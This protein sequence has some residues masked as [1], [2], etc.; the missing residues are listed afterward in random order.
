M[1]QLDLFS[2]LTARLPDEEELARRFSYFNQ[3]YFEGS[4]P[5][6]NVLW[7]SRMRIAGTCDSRRRV[8]TLSRAYH[9]HFPND[10]DD[11]LKH[12]MI[13]LKQHS[14]DAAFRREA[15]RVGA[16]IHCKEYP[17]L[18]PRARFV[19]ICPRC[20]TLFHRS[21][22]ER[23]YCGLCARNRLDARFILVL[24]PSARRNESAV[25]LAARRP[26]RNRP[27]HRASH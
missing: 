9:A 20:R 19:Y 23:L 4:L 14:H 12:E 5:I 10:V 27:K 8:I 3:R 22:R 2:I 13:H 1:T 6:T 25:P 15:E 18:H 21:K 16:T 26:A 24:R 7:S 11:T 17:G